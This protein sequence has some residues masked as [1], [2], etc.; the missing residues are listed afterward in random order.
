MRDIIAARVDAVRPAPP[1][2]IGET[3]ALRSDPARIGVITGIT[4]SN[5]ETRLSVFIDGRLETLYVSQVMRADLT[6]GAVRA[7]LSEFNARLTALQLA[8]PSIANCT[9]FKLAAS[10]S[11]RTSSGPC[12]NSSAPT[13][14]GCWSLTKWVWARRLK[15]VSCSANCRHAVHCVQCLSFARRRWWWRKN[16]IAR[17]GV[18]MRSL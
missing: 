9:R 5:R 12:S 4:P 11:F 18:L 15:L 1:L 17:C 3:V 13:A 10:T 14:R 6:P 8:E 7:T 16:G 2:Q